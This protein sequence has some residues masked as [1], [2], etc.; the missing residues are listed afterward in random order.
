MTAAKHRRVHR[1]IHWLCRAV[2]IRRDG[3]VILFE[4]PTFKAVANGIGAWVD[5]A[6]LTGDEMVVVTCLR[7]GALNGQHT[8]SASELAGCR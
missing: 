1:D 6:T 4:E 8:Y 5:D 7:D 3:T 2:V